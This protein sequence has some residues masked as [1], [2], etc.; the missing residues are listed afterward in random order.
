MDEEKKLTLQQV[1]CPSCKR[2]INTFNP[3]KLM[4][5]CPYCHSKLVNPLVKPKKVMVPERIIPFTTDEQAFETSLVNALINQ[6]YVPTDIFENISTGDVI[7]AYLPMYLFEGTYNASWSCE[8]AYKDQEVK[9][10]S[11]S[12][13]TKDVKKWRPQNG[14][15]AGNFSFLCL[16]N[17]GNDIPDE[18]RQFARLFP[19]DIMLSKEFTQ[20]MIDYND[21]N[22][23]TLEC[24]ADATLVWQKHGK[25]MVE[26]TAQ[27]AALNQIGDQ[28]IRNFRASSSHNLTTM[29]R[30][31]F[32]PFWF[33]YYKYNDTQYHYLMD[34]TGGHT[35]YSYPSDQEEIDYVKGKERV[36]KIVKWLWLL[37]IAFLAIFSNF[38]VAIIYLAVWFI[39][40]IVVKKVMQNKIQQRLDESKAKRQECANQ[41]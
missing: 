39:G 9:I 23:M 33:V 30:Y 31:V 26:E 40:K 16:A 6:D 5:E 34:G 19:Y 25:E 28:E 32:V 24:N 17:E 41:L 20:D 3:N 22:L 11:N 35:S 29:G 10:S 7:Q 21:D 13:R 8:S 27:K 2:P 36:V 15:A 37:A 1:T 38:T 12:V 14:N 18:L 4:A